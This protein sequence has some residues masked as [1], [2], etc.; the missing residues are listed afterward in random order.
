MII[1]TSL[2]EKI[3]TAK[4]TKT[5][6]LIAKYI[7][8]N[9]SLVGFMTVLDLAKAIG[10][11]DA[12]VIRM[13]RAIGYSGYNDMQKDIQKNISHKVTYGSNRTL[14]P[15][16]KLSTNIDLLNSNEVVETLLATAIKN[17]Q[18]SI[19]TN[20]L[21]KINLV[22]DIIIKSKRKFFV[23]FRISSAIATAMSV[24]IGHILPDVRSITHAD[25]TSLE[26]LNDLTEDDCVFF[27]S[28]PRYPKMVDTLFN[29]AKES[30]AKIILMTE[31]AASPHASKADIIIPVS[32]DSISFL[33]SYMAPMFIAELIA[34]DVSRK[35]ENIGKTR[36][37]RM[38]KF[39]GEAGLY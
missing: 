18:H 17:V 26:S 6:R 4:L 39:V 25:F 23:G 30:S 15:S 14:T 38:D 12:S 29:M 35:N 33:N 27:I 5:E 2:E 19:G 34:T 36:M 7:L 8:E 20:T 10:T 9:E 32:V 1:N 3:L 22:S 11:S 31:S 24:S 37:K 16:D 13:A 21:D 28:F